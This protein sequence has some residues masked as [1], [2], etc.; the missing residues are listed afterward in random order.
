MR[1]YL[2]L[3]FAVN[4]YQSTKI[5]Y[6]MYFYYIELPAPIANT[7]VPTGNTAAGRARVLNFLKPYGT[8]SK[9]DQAEFAR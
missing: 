2:P 9:Q 5:K 7:N 3:L 8:V 4:N 1:I 6:G